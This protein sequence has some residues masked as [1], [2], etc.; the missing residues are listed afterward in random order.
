MD[1]NMKDCHTSSI[2]IHLKC[3]SVCGARAVSPHSGIDNALTDNP[4]A[5]VDVIIRTFDLL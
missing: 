5:K 2:G 4:D 1:S 3:K